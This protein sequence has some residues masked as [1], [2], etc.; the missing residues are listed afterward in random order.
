MKDNTRERLYKCFDEA[1]KVYNGRLICSLVGSIQFFESFA[2]RCADEFM[3][4]LYEE[5]CKTN[6]DKGVTS[7]KQ[8]FLERIQRLRDA[9]VG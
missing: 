7:D 4:E 8:N 5:W 1:A 3:K 6:V 2:Y 9:L